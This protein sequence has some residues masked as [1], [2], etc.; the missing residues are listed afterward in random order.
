MVF[1]QGVDSSYRGIV[2]DVISKS[3]SG[4]A[5]V[6]RRVTGITSGSGGVDH[7]HGGSGSTGGPSSTTSV[8][9]GYYY[10]S[11]VTD[12]GASTGGPSGTTSVASD[13]HTH[14]VG[15]DTGYSKGPAASLTV[16]YSHT[17][18][19]GEPYQGTGSEYWSTG[20]RIY[21]RHSTDIPT[22][23]KSV[24]SDSHTH[25]VS[26]STADYGIT[27]PHFVSVAS[28]GHTHSVSGSTG[29]ASAYSHIHSV[30]SPT[31]S[32]SFDWFAVLL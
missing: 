11:V 30:D 13:T 12:V 14:S 24:A 21:H 6:A 28:S 7:T 9:D 2:L 26:K 3:R 22:S 31:L 20:Y 4:F 1:L 15:T 32:V 5:V 10:A 29:G 8:M 17:A 23:A 25:T 27:G 16:Y 19:T 18:S